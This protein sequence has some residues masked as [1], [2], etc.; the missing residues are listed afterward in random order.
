MKSSEPTPLGMDN[1]P[2]EDALDTIDGYTVGQEGEPQIFTFGDA[3]SHYAWLAVGEERHALEGE[4]FTIPKRDPVLISKYAT[5]EEMATDLTKKS[6]IDKELFHQ[7]LNMLA[8]QGVLHSYDYGPPPLPR[9]SAEEVAIEEFE[10]SCLSVEDIREAARETKRKGAN[11]DTPT[12]M[13]TNADSGEYRMVSLDA[14][15]LIADEQIYI[16]QSLSAGYRQ[17]DVC[18]NTFVEIEEYMARQ[19]D[20]LK[21]NKN[22]IAL[23]GAKGRRDELHSTDGLLSHQPLAISVDFL[24]AGGEY[25]PANADPSGDQPPPRHSLRDGSSFMRADS[26]DAFDFLNAAQ[27]MMNSYA[28][29]LQNFAGREILFQPLPPLSKSF[30]ELHQSV[31][32]H[33]FELGYIYIQVVPPEPN[34]LIVNEKGGPEKYLSPILSSDVRISLENASR[35]FERWK[36]PKIRKLSAIALRKLGL[37]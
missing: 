36:Q 19:L 28:E 27:T 34:F 3:V 9:T 20:S 14:V 16:T 7:R 32:K 26:Y 33:G 13:I 23:F 6:K 37:A 29:S 18:F 10:R 1:Y 17:G 35:H 15:K 24:S 2:I 4:S 12:L 30:I 31:T 8:D 22:N 5:L 11:K 21:L 25:S